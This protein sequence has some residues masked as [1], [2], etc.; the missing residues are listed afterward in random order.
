MF[1]TTVPD[2]AVLDAQ[3]KALFTPATASGSIATF[4]NGGDDI[5]VSEFECEIVAQQGS[6]T[7]NPSDPL[8]ITGFSQADITVCGKNLFDSSTLV[9]GGVSSTGIDTVSNVRVRSGYF[10][11]PSGDY[12]IKSD[13]YIDTVNFYDSADSSTFI[14][15]VIGSSSQIS[16]T[17]T[18]GC[19]VRIAFRKPNTSAEIIPSEVTNTQLEKGE[20][21]TTYAAY[22]GNLYT[23]SFGQTI[24]GG[25]LI[26]A[27]GQ[28][29]IEATHREYVFDG[30]E[31]P[32]TY[33]SGYRYVVLTGKE[34]KSYGQY[35]TPNAI[36]NQ[37]VAISRNDIQSGSTGF[38][39]T[40][41][42]ILLSTDTPTGIQ[43]VY[44]LAS[45]VIIPITSS[46]RVKTISGDNNIYSNTGDCELKYFTD[47]SDTIADIVE[48]V[49]YT[50]EQTD[51]EINEVR[52]TF[53]TGTLTAGS[54]SITLSDASITTTSTI[55]IYTSTFGIQP[56]NAV[57]A[58]GSIT[59]TFLAQASDITVKV[60]VS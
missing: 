36:S 60:R 54:T 58:T 3:L 41:D 29:S 52:G 46:T 23:V 15:R 50:K 34:G 47:G 31:T 13:V 53:V 22:T 33:G 30:T 48:Q 28:W 25:R 37:Y 12:I 42:T 17:L 7:P 32:I 11:L 55:D 40:G 1:S 2:Q 26:Y 45:P 38:S 24:Y 49:S 10:Y 14:S 5:P 39:L 8:P 16:F 21:P 19:Y 56:T 6:G 35:D 59:L 27:N 57:V 4:D 51:A 44:E 18:N 43:I 9:Q 20:Q